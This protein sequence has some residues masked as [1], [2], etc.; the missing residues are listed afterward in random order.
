[1]IHHCVSSHS[2]FV[3]SARDAKATAT[4]MRN[5]RS[6]R[7][8]ATRAARR[9]D[10][11]EKEQSLPPRASEA[12]MLLAQQQDAEKQQALAFSPTAL[13]AGV[14]VVR[15]L[16]QSTRLA[17]IGNLSANG[18]RA[19]A[20]VDDAAANP[21]SDAHRTRLFGKLKAAFRQ[22]AQQRGNGNTR[23]T[24]TLQAAGDTASVRA[25]PREYSC[26]HITVHNHSRITVST[27]I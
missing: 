21:N 14:R 5:Q 11:E 6:R 16:N 26:T 7:Y 13:D 19:R 27:I 20:T 25:R 17:E 24:A 10:A 18:I 4:V 23:D 15:L 3:V 1:M 22:W 8:W 12:Q 2:S 9:A